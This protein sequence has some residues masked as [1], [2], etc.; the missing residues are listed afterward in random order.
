MSHPSRVRGLKSAKAVCAAAKLVVASFTGAWI[1]I[2]VVAE[3][4]ETKRSHPL[5]VRGLKFLRFEWTG[6]LPKLHH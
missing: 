3:I 5:R 4:N 6:L 2:D 1:E